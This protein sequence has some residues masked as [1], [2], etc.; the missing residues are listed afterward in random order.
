METEELNLEPEEQSS[1]ARAL[2]IIVLAL[3]ALLIGLSVYLFI[4]LR[5]TKAQTAELMNQLTVHEE[6]IAQLEGTVNRAE[7]T[8]DS[9]LQELKGAVEAAEK[10]LQQ[11]TQQVEQRVL[12]KT[13]QL[14]EQLEREKQ[15]RAAK[16]SA[17]GG[18]LEKLNETTNTRLGSLSGTVDVVKD[19][20]EKTKAE[21][22]KTIAELKSVKGDLGVQSGLIATNA[23]ELNALR[24]LGERNYFEFDLTKTKQPQR[25]GPIQIKLRGTK[26]KR[27]QYTIDI[28]ADDN[29]IRKKNKTLLE[30]V[31]FYVIGSKI[32]YEIVV[33]QIE[34][35]R[36]VGYLAAPKVERRRAV[37]SSSGS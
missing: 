2:P 10:G 7:R 3:L 14:A 13:N 31:Q 33:N 27:N 25:V 16:L 26:H 34:K 24:E 6:Q 9:G 15:E 35:R 21:L 19:E 17:V 5:A 28:W 37:A 29:R 18:E 32:P 22:E 36:I 30:P 23:E 11:T 20:V 4:D 8:V 1:Q 12:G